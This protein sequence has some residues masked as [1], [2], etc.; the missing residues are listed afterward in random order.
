M[1]LNLEGCVSDESGSKTFSA[2]TISE[3]NAGIMTGQSPVREPVFGRFQN[4]R[5]FGMMHPTIMFKDSWAS[6]TPK[7]VLLARQMILVA[8]TSL[9]TL[10]S[11]A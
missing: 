1:K 10:T 7:G 2:E 11:L 5:N 9:L 6:L 3:E 8:T 4:C